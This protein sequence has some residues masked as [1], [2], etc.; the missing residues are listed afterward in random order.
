[1]R[2][3]L[4]VPSICTL[5]LSCRW[6]RLVR[7]LAV[8]RFTGEIDLFKVTDDFIFQVLLL[9]LLLC[10]VSALHSA[11]VADRLLSSKPHDCHGSTDRRFFSSAHA[12]ACARVLLGVTFDDGA[13]DKSE[14]RGLFDEFFNGFYGLL[15]RGAAGQTFGNNP[16]FC[17]SCSPCSPLATLHGLSCS[18]RARMQNISALLYCS[19]AVLATATLIFA[20]FCAVR[21]AVGHPNHGVW[22]GHAGAAGAAGGR[23]ARLGRAGRVGRRLDDRLCRQSAGRAEV[24]YD[25]AHHQVCRR[26]RP[27]SKARGLC[28]RYLECNMTPWQAEL[29][30]W[31]TL[32]M[33]VSNHIRP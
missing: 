14:I 18:I 19:T 22:E 26:A 32:A 11:P 6:L 28:Q 31:V 8:L 30:C 17:G 10:L 20:V 5:F 13:Y 4:D 33:V 1:M 12:Q 21:A 15:V 2:R 24:R 27:L 29:C 7:S 3:H 23:G 9:E 16:I 25:W